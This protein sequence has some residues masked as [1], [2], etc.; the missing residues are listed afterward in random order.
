MW[1]KKRKVVKPQA[2]SSSKASVT[3]EK[4]ENFLVWRL[5]W[6]VCLL[7]KT[8]SWQELSRKCEDKYPSAPKTFLLRHSVK[9]FFCVV[10]TN[11]YYY[12][13]IVD[14]EILLIAIEK[15]SNESNQKRKK[16]CMHIGVIKGFL[17]MLA[18]I[19]KFEN[20]HGRRL[21]KTCLVNICFA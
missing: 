2:A 21:N 4:I 9:T 13:L 14:K 3:Y 5:L 11:F 7:W 12:W 15:K 17:C 8:T 10:Y 19:L 18:I 16:S 20:Y 6:M 1:Q